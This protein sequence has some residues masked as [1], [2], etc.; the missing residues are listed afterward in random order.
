MESTNGNDSLPR[1]AGTWQ[2]LYLPAQGMMAVWN[3][4]RYSQLVIPSYTIIFIWAFGHQ[5]LK[6][7]QANYMDAW[8]CVSTLRGDG[9]AAAP[10]SLPASLGKQGFTK[11]PMSS[12]QANW[13][14]TK[15]FQGSKEIWRNLI[16]QRH[17]S[18]N[19]TTA[20]L[21][22]KFPFFS[23]IETIAILHWCGKMQE[24]LRCRLGSCARIAV[25]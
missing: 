3:S 7:F 8:K 19:I 23:S 6:S 15:L 4:G 14:W 2:E 24:V 9:Q 10:E 12:H 11:L 20:W 16:V 13:H 25:M 17:V 1:Y 5:K 22:L 21:G 18:L